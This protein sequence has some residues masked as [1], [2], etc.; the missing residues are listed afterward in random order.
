[1]IKKISVITGSRAEYGLLKNLILLL[2]QDKSFKTSL[3]LTGSHLSK[4]FG[5]T[6]NE[7]KK[8]KIYINHKI[9]LN[10]TNDQPS[11]ISREIGKSFI[12]FSKIF[13]KTKPHLIIVLG[14]RYEL[15]PAVYAATIFQIPIAHIHGGELS[16][17][18]MDDVTRHAITKL[19]HLHF[20]AHRI[21]RNRVIQMGEQPNKVFNFGGLGVDAI[22]KEKLLDKKKLEKKLKIK[23]KKKNILVSYHPETIERKKNKLY[24]KELLK[25]LK[26]K[27]DILYIFTYP[28]ADSGNN[29]LIKLIEIFCKKNYLNTVKFKSLGNKLFWSLIKQV[30]GVIG[31]SSSGLLEVPTFNKGTINIGERQTNRLKSASVIDCK[32]KKKE[33]LNAIQKIYSRKFATKISK[34]N[35]LYGNGGASKKIFRILKKLN[36]KTLIKKKFFDLK[37]I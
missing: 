4:K 31:N 10:L 3:I 7:I 30:D 23:L 33:I 16:L 17:G 14:D 2:K 34:V 32:P 18:S 29:E 24:F 6:F 28:N 27:K 22:K 8:D 37:K 11:N 13:K 36:L 25:A 12:N 15:L 20:T 21:Y 1:M 9:K 35:N 5:Y 19:S 26:E